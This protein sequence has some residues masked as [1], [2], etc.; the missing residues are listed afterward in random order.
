M[1]ADSFDIKVFIM[2]L[3]CGNCECPNFHEWV[4][5]TCYAGE[6]LLGISNR[7]VP[8]GCDN[9]FQQQYSPS[10]SLGCQQ[11]VAKMVSQVE[12]KLQL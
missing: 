4:S 11:E 12:M 8:A 3:N 5:S 1:R 9:W 7:V 2:D 10:K 6:V